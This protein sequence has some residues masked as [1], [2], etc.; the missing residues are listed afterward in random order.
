[1]QL[2]SNPK[3][4]YDGNNDQIIKIMHGIKLDSNRCYQTTYSLRCYLLSNGPLASISFIFFFLSFFFHSFS[5]CLYI[6]SINQ[7]NNSFIHFLFLSFII[8]LYL[9]LAIKSAANLENMSAIFTSSP[10]VA[11]FLSSSKNASQH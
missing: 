7:P 6:P 8:L 5:L 11:F 2:R 4:I 1:M 9:T 10:P 3:A